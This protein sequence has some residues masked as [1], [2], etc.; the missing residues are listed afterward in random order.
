VANVI[1]AQMLFLE[2]DDPDKDI[3]IYVNSPGGSVM[4]GLAIYDTMQFIK[5]DV[6]TTVVGQA[7]SMAA[8]I[9]AAGA[10][11]KRYALP[12]A[13]V[14][15]HQPMGGFQG[16]VSDIEIHSREMLRIKRRLSEI[17]AEHTG[18]DVAKIQGDSDRDHF[19]GAQESLEYGLIDEVM[20]KRLAG[21]KAAR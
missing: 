9:L 19:M 5:P 18:Q 2:Y 8:L 16:Q 17:F 13:R 21:V 7:S 20:T 14:M 3:T 1:I 10:K 15:I 6:S 11:G 4:A 12:H